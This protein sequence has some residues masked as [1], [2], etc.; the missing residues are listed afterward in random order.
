MKQVHR[1]FQSIFGLLLMLSVAVWSVQ[2]VLAQKASYE[3]TFAQS[4]TEVERAL[5]HLQPEASGRLPVL[6]GFTNPGD[7]GLDHF[8]RGYYQCE[9]QVSE[10]PSGGALV[11]VS[12][13]ITAW[14]SGPTAAES[15]YQT[16]PSN[17]RLET[18]FLDRLQDT[19]S[20]KTSSPA[21]GASMTTPQT[22]NASS[23][24]TQNALA[25]KQ[26]QQL[27]K[28]AKNLEEIL[29]NQVHPNNLVAVKKS[30]T[31]ILASP[32]EGAKVLLL[33]SAE[34]EFEVLDMNAGW[35][36][37]RIS[38][39]SRGWIR[40]ADLEMPEGVTSAAKGGPLPANPQHFEVKDEQTTTFPGTWEPLRGKMVKILTVQKTSQDSDPAGPRAKLEFAKSLFAREYT[41]LSHAPTSA[42]GVVL[43]FDSVDGGMAAAPLATLQEWRTGSL[44]DQAFWRRCYFDPPE[45]FNSPT[46][47]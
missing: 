47:Q 44:S 46:G 42:A 36:H 35:V 32:I 29:R 17:G 1:A 21:I 8:E 16:L 40:R 15:G 34:D 13:K 22:K 28:E 26:K 33:A 24:A 23:L 31:P 18:D 11:R 9:A 27:E 43:I 20:G 25:D 38:G 41:E 7:R 4:K 39:V 2:P 5:K 45:T 37:V 30:K 3:R 6:D 19:L 14:Y 12:A 10:T